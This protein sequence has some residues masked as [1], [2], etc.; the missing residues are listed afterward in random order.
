MTYTFHLASRYLLY[1][2]KQTVVLILAY[3]LVTG[4]P[5]IVSDFLQ[6]FETNLYHRASSTPMVIGSKGSKFDLSFH[7]LYFKGEVPGVLS[8]QVLSN[9]QSS[10]L[11]SAIPLYLAHTAKGYPVVG[12]SLD[13]LTLRGLEVA[14]GH[15]M[16][17]LGECV[18]GAAVAEKLSLQPGASLI[19]DPESVFDLAGDYPLKM[20]VAGILKPM[21]TADDQAIFV[22]TK[23]AWVISGIGHGHERVEEANQQTI[24]KD[25]GNH[26]VA[27]SALLHYNEIKADNRLS[28][29]FHADA[30]DLP[31]TAV[32]AVPKDTKS[33][34]LLRGR[35]LAASN[36]IQ[37]LIPSVVIEE[38]FGIIFK[39]K[40]FFDL[41]THLTLG[42]M[43]LLLSLIATLTFRIRAKE[44]QMLH[45]VGCPKGHVITIQI[46][47]TLLV[48]LTGTILAAL[49]WVLARHFLH[50]VLMTRMIGL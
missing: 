9:I 10:G 14:Q 1:H 27:N 34:T 21:G 49:G 20:R 2:W 35:F 24:L 11:A 15:T 26:I 31:L 30:E 36:P 42:A 41:Q 7:S 43:A 45:S 29:H 18:L 39:V 22:D 28:F 4:F 37:I 25:Q 19:S 5:F 47:E 8:S 13:Y 16:T 44:R 17:S 38:L 40:T 3:A 33:S 12:T 6:T 46:L 23:T 48:F 50:D 32:I